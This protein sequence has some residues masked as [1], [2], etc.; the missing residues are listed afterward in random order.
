LR[1]DIFYMRALV[2]SYRRAD[3]FGEL[4]EEIHRVR[5][6]PAAVGA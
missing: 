5:L 4:A 1:W 3:Q 2:A 6:M